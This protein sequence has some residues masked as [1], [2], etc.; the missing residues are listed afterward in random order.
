MSNERTTVIFRNKDKWFYD[1]IVKMVD[2]KRYMGL[3]TSMSFEILRL[4]KKGLLDSAEGAD[5]DRT[6]LKGDKD[7]VAHES[8]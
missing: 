8:T 1:W 5:L 2:T 4:A 3:R 6:I 7:D